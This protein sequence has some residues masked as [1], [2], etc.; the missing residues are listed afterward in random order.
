MHK[1][2][3]RALAGAGPAAPAS[4]SSPPLSG[5]GNPRLSKEPPPPAP[6]AEGGTHA[7]FLRR[8]RPG[9]RGSREGLEPKRFPASRLSCSSPPEPVTRLPRPFIFSPTPPGRLRQAP[10]GPVIRQPRPRYPP[11]RGA[12]IP[13]PQL[14]GPRAGQGR[15]RLGAASQARTAAGGGPAVSQRGRPG[16]AAGGGGA[17][18][19]LGP[20]AGRRRRR[21]RR[22]GQLRAL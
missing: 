10:P 17:E 13:R 21:G 5:P 4:P 9:P 8:V 19:G 20:G 1:F 16:R 2:P 18:D 6:P 15:S 14:W 3:S 12:P 7:P 22:R 11:S